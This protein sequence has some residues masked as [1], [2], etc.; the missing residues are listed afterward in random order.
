[1]LGQGNEQLMINLINNCYSSP[2]CRFKSWTAIYIKVRKYTFL[3]TELWKT[4]KDWAMKTGLELLW[5]LTG[6]LHGQS[7]ACVCRPLINWRAVTKDGNLQ[8]AQWLVNER[9]A[10]AKAWSCR[11]LVSDQTPALISGHQW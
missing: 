1:M 11:G 5:H 9:Q 4:E 2:L 3:S 6:T 10:Q 7:F 8:A